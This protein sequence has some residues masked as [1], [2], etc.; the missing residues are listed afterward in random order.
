MRMIRDV[1]LIGLILLSACD[2][3]ADSNF[4]LS[5]EC[6]LPLWFQQPS[7]VPRNDLSVELFYYRDHA[8]FVLRNER[9]G[10]RLAKVRAQILNGTPLRLSDE[11]TADGIRPLYKIMKVDGMVEIVE[12]RRREA[13]FDISDDPDVRTKLLTM[14]GNEALLKQ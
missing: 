9:T 8:V 5:S 7:G 14:T 12:H 2:F 11:R 3:I 1:L 10:R 13:V 6:R 4:M